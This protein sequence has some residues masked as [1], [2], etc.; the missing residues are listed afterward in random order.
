M[1]PF[2]WRVKRDTVLGK[3]GSQDDMRVGEKGHRESHPGGRR[4]YQSVNTTAT[5]LG[6]GVGGGKKGGENQAG[7]SGGRGHS[8]RTEK[9]K[10][11]P[12]LVMPVIH[13]AHKSLRAAAPKCHSMPATTLVIHPLGR[14][15]EETP[16]RCKYFSAGIRCQRFPTLLRGLIIWDLGKNTDAVAGGGGGVP[17]P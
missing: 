5:R 3:E 12:L 16:K 10:E 6:M 9:E 17:R 4:C 13:E 2:L 15:W 7:S 14:S 8:H 1:S 11:A